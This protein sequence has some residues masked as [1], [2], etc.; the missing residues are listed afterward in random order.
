MKQAIILIVALLAISLMTGV[1]AEQ[2]EQAFDPKTF[3]YNKAD[4]N[5]ITDWSVVD[6]TKIPY[7]RIKDVPPDKL[8]Y[9]KLS[10][11]Q[12]YSGMTKEQIAANL[13]KIE[14]LYHDVSPTEVQ[15]VIES[16]YDL[17]DVWIGGKAQIRD[18][19]LHCAEGQQN[20]IDLNRLA[21]KM[22]IEV[23]PDGIIRIEPEFTLLGARPYSGEFPPGSYEVVSELY[24]IPFTLDG[25]EVRIMGAFRFSN[26]R[27]YAFKKERTLPTING[28]ALPQLSEPVEIFLDGEAHEGRYLSIDESNKRVR[29]GAGK[30]AIN[31]AFTEENKFLDITDPVLI[32]ATS[33][34]EV[35]VQRRS[36]SIPLITSTLPSDSTMDM[37]N[38]NNIYQFSAKTLTLQVNPYKT[39]NP[40]E[41]KPAKVRKPLPMTMLFN[42]EKGENMLETLGKKE[43]LI[44][45]EQGN[46]VIIEESMPAETTECFSCARDIL[47]NSDVEQYNVLLYHRLGREILTLGNIGELRTKGDPYIARLL[48]SSLHDLP[49]ELLKSV[50]NI[51]V[52]SRE[53]L[54]ELCKSK[55]IDGCASEGGIIYL[56]ED[57]SRETVFHEAGH[58]RTLDLAQDVTRAEMEFKAYELVLLRKYGED[59]SA[60]S[61]ETVWTLATEEETQR[62]SALQQKA[63]QEEQK[64]DLEERW[65]TIA[66]DVYGTTLL[67][68]PEEG[69][70]YS[71]EWKDNT[72]GPRQGCIRAYGCNNY[73]EDIATFVE[74]IANG[75]HEFFTREGLIMPP[76]HPLYD[77]AKYDPRY[78]QKLDLLLEYQFIT[79]EDYRKILQPLGLGYQPK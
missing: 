39:E 46:F 43:K 54:K 51:N 50:R 63:E 72:K 47:A 70:D 69:R 7:E 56:P 15:K 1:L 4:Y 55:N 33:G 3:D 24:E 11:L 12:R 62:L 36:D 52:V 58:T 27:L 60:N 73:L 38:G 79:E 6:W 64:D 76:G 40:E 10:W 49:P 67:K 65:E 26:G 17:S 35:L 14:D 16:K 8:V 2:H 68:E 18:G 61:R 22:R 37:V 42:D 78:K 74:P 32:S 23:T 29:F 28:I 48:L 45:D 5:L 44:M 53:R 75:D 9:E 13:E 71:T 21:K 57:F 20:S 41:G 34:A 66:D 25:K 77:S 31:V 19:I 30:D 59:I